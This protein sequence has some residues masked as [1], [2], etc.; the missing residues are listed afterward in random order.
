MR[1]AASDDVVPPLFL[2]YLFKNISYL[3]YKASSYVKCPSHNSFSYDIAIFWGL[4]MHLEFSEHVAGILI[5]WLTEGIVNKKIQLIRRK[6]GEHLL[7]F[8]MLF[9][10]SYMLIFSWASMPLNIQFL[11]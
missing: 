10:A 8:W 2:D 11:K 3:S 5:K 4:F 6:I 1:P 9:I 7:A